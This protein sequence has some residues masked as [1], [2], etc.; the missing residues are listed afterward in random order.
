KPPLTLRQATPSGG[1]H[2]IFRYPPDR[3]IRCRAP[4][5]RDY[6]GIDIRGNDGYIVTP[7]SINGNGKRWRWLNDAEIAEAPDWLIDLVQ[8]PGQS[9]SKSN[10][11]TDAIIYRE[12]ERNNALT[13]LAGSMRHRGMTP[14]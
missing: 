8:Q 2:L 7:P 11:T 9:K 1:F 5:N 12:G 10:G 3:E 13:S 14:E 6:P 4:F